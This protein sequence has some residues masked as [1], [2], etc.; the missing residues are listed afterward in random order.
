[1]ALFTCACLPFAVLLSG[2]I[3]VPEMPQ[4]P[5]AD[6]RVRAGAQVRAPA[7]Q[8]AAK[9]PTVERSTTLQ[10]ASQALQIERLE[11]RLGSATL[12]AARL[13]RIDPE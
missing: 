13:R 10:D 11:W 5:L 3:A 7:P 4:R 8:S 2:T 9:P 1:M 12:E 6:D